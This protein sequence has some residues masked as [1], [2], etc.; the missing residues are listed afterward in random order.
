MKAEIV[1][2][3]EGLRAKRALIRPS[4]RML[5]SYV[6]VEVVLNSESS[7]AKLANEVL[8]S[9]GVVGV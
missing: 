1:D 6:A 9:V 3:S 2:E 5:P 7:V 8:G 4:A